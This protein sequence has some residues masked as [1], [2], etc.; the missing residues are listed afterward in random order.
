M[1]VDI[2]KQSLLSMLKI[3]LR[4]EPVKVEE[5]NKPENEIKDN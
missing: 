4:V 2:A 5:E 3:E 1:F